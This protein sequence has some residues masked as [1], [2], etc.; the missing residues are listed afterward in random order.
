MLTRRRQY[1]RWVD[2]AMKSRGVR[3]DVLLMQPRWSDE[4]V[5]R[6]QVME[7]VLGVVHLYRADR[8]R[9]KVPLKLFKRDPGGGMNGAFDREL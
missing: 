6:R 2:N 8:M 4:A 7:G 3:V 1:I 5:V 9:N